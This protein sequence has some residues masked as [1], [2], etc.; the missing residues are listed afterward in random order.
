M[1]GDLH[2]GIEALIEDWADVVGPADFGLA[3]VANLR[4]LLAAHPVTIA[5]AWDRG[6]TSGQSRTMRKMSDEPNV[7]PGVNPYRL[8]GER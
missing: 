7:K 3:P 2:A 8:A 6:Y 5:E 1:T 4:A